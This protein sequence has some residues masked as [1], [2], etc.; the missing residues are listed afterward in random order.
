MKTWAWAQAAASLTPAL[1]QLAAS[2]IQQQQQNLRVAFEEQLK[3]NAAEQLKANTAE[4]LQ[5]S[6]TEQL[7]ATASQ[8]PTGEDSSGST[9]AASPP[10]SDDSP[11]Q[12]LAKS[13][14][15][16][17][18]SLRKM[19]GASAAPSTMSS[20][21]GNTQLQRQD[22][23]PKP[24]THPLIPAVA[25][26]VPNPALSSK[27]QPTPSGLPTST[28]D[29]ALLREALA[30][31]AQ[32]AAKTALPPGDSSTHP[33]PGIPVIVQTNRPLHA[34]LKNS[35]EAPKL[36]P[37]QKAKTASSK[38]HRAGE[39][40][41][42]KTIATT[43]PK[44]AS[45]KTKKS[46]ED[47]K[48]PEDEEAATSLL[49]LLNSLRRSYEDAIG[50]T[51]DDSVLDGEETESNKKKRARPSGTISISRQSP[52]EQGSSKSIT[53]SDTNSTKRSHRRQRRKIGKESLPRPSELQ[54]KL[55]QK[56]T[57]SHG[58]RPASVTDTSTL[59]RSETSS[60]T[61]SQPN[62]S[63]SSV[64]DS[65]S[66]DKTD[67]SSSEES[68]DKD[69]SIPQISQGPPRKRHKARRQV[70]E[71]TTEN[72]LEHSKLMTREMK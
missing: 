32:Q 18:E 49:G 19:S 37:Q 30:R 23:A 26:A 48:S 10:T 47:K 5:S 46:G 56:A 9:S 21:L 35:G 31:A 36:P 63:S 66:L 27:P 17:L 34:S 29:Q 6:S 42:K 71:F 15:A 25:S 3:A 22:Q 45:T 51:I 57:A 2:N 52:S 11:A 7:K 60:G 40:Q 67:P 13:Y 4:Q 20:I 54:T 65:E 72:V 8:E 38:S 39:Q 69:Y 55:I 44:K 64:E 41:K 53:S 62:E 1:T 14:E 70:Q 24:P 58:Y 61:S 50:S 28:V 43:E 33:V 59:S 68:S 16:H 12:Q